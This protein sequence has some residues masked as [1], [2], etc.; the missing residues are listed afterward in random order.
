VGRREIIFRGSLR[1]KKS[2][3]ATKIN[4]YSPRKKNHRDRRDENIA[5]RNQRE[6]LSAIRS[7]QLARVAQALEEGLMQARFHFGRQRHGLGVAVDLDCFARCIH[8][9][10]AFFAAIE[11]TFEIGGG[12]GVQRLVQIAR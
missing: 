4:S 11:M 10:P 3:L 6:T 5:R 2:T 12:H 8:D 7:K 1:E 9:Q